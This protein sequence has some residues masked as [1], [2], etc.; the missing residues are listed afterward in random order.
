MRNVVIMFAG[1]GAQYIGMGKDFYENNKV[2][3]QIFNQASQILGYDIRH[4]CFEAN[5][6]INQTQYTQPA[7]LVTSLAI[8]HALVDRL[9][10]NPQFMLGFSLGEYSALYASGIISFEDIIMLIQKRANFMAQ[11][12]IDHPGAMAAI[13]GI[14]RNKLS[15]ICQ[16]VTRDEGFVHIANYNCPNQLVISGLKKS[17]EMVCEFAKANGAK[18][19]ILLNV[20]GGFHTPLMKESADKMLHQVLNI[21]HKKPKTDIIMNTDASVLINLLELP[22]KMAN[23]ISGPVYF[24]DSV[25]EAIRRGANTFIEIGPGQVLSGLVRKIDESVDVVSIDK[26]SDLDKLNSFLGGNSYEPRK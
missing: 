22:Y 25:R 24:E 17:V 5:D 10:L 18:R 1:Q 7:M 13:L 11:D 8:Y 23:Q 3:K 14:D 21:E 20:S 15:S 26:Y 9:P 2:S 16:D 19:A 12:A 6:N 4:I